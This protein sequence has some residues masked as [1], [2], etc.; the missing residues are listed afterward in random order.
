M[1]SSDIRV[2][3][4]AVLARKRVEEDLDD[5]L[6]FHIEMQARKN[7]AEGISPPEA[8]RLARIQ[9]GVGDTAKEE[10]R[11]AR[12][13]QMFDEFTRDIAYTFRNLRRDA[14]FT[15]LAILI[16]G[17][18]IGASATVF[19]IVNTLLLRP[20]PFTEPDRLVWI[21]NVPVNSVGE[22]AFQVDH[23]L[24]LRNQSRSFSDL[25]GYFD[26][27]KPGDSKLAGESQPVSL[28]GIQISCGL[29]PLLGVKP[30][31]GN[32]FTPEQCKW[33]ARLPKDSGDDNEAH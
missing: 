10:C 31:V 11:D 17:L 30:V 26:F 32:Q 6:A 3:L 5:E 33:N 23:V 13:V 20:L 22:W 14:G 21:S 15:T 2:R 4:R 27:S 19:S 1:S 28:T 16:A 12:G 25:E 7:V 9:F 24:D 8:N 29:F 18:G